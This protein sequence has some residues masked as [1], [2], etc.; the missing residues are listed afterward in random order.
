MVQINLPKK[1]AA[2]D[3]R[4]DDIAR[5]CRAMEAATV[6]S[7]PF[8]HAVIQDVLSPEFLAEILAVYPSHD[9]MNQVSDRF[10]GR[11]YDHRRLSQSLP[12]PGSPE[13]REVPAAFRRL[14]GL[15]CSP[16]FI[17]SALTLLHNPIKDAI[18]YYAQFVRFPTMDIRVSIELILDRSGFALRPHTDGRFKLVTGLLYLAE[19]GNPEELGTRL[20]RPKDPNF[21]SDGSSSFTL[22]TFEEVKLVPYRRNQMLIFGRTDQSFH[23]VAAT[24]SDVPRRLIQ[25][26]IMATRE[27]V[28]TVQNLMNAI[29]GMEKT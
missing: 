10:P 20:Y 25:F 1:Y 3:G 27:Q 16:A 24:D 22:D 23:G 6:E 17:K 7:A 29:A 28:Q 9:T 2:T 18:S 15:L 11:K 14:S 19:P 5:L 4:Q 12:D 26:S 13:M 8:E 21:R